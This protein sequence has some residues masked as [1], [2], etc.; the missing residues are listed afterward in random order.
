MSSFNHFYHVPRLMSGE[1]GDEFFVLRQG[2]ASVTVHT[3]KGD[4][5]RGLRRFA[6]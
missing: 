1:M 5:V 3:V 4:K 6:L 2:E